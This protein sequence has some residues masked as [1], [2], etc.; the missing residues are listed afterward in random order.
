MKRWSFTTPYSSSPPPTTVRSCGMISSK[1]CCV[2]R[3]QLC[4]RSSPINH[5]T[6]LC[7]QERELSVRKT[8]AGH[9]GSNHS[10]PLIIII[11]IIIPFK[12]KHYPQH[13]CTHTANV[14]SEASF[15][16]FFRK[17]NRLKNHRPFRTPSTTLQI[18]NIYC[19]YKKT[20]REVTLNQHAT[21]DLRARGSD[22]H[23]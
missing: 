9:T 7:V 3:Y 20:S 16:L 2:A 4:V 12:S 19:K 14:V 11:I 6:S 10:L 8:L 22:I 23:Q 17:E 15:I 21:N 13:A 1:T 18:S 5:K